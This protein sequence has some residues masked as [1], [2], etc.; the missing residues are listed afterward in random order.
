VHGHRIPK[1]SV[2]HRQFFFTE[3][4]PSGAYSVHYVYGPVEKVECRIEGK[5]SGMPNVGLGSPILLDDG[6]YRSYGIARSTDQRMMSTGIWESDDALSWRPRNLGQVEDTNLILFENLPGDQSSLA[7]TSVLRLADGRWR[8]YLWKHREGHLRLI[9]AESDDG[10][11]WRVLDLEK[12]VLYHPHDGG[13]WKLAEGLAVHEA[14]KVEMP[15]EEVMRRKR[16]WTNDSLGIYYNEQIGR[17]ECYGVWLH[18]A[19]PDRRVDVDNAPGVHRLIYRRFSEDGIEWSDPELII[20]PDE[21]DPWDLQFYFLGVQWYEDFMIGSLGYYRVEDGQQS[22]DTDLCFSRDGYRWDRPLRGGWIPRSEE[23]S[24]MMDT[25]GIYAGDRWIDR[26][27]RW[28]ILYHGTPEPHNSRECVVGMMGAVF[29]KNR[30]IGVAAGRVPGGFMTEPFFLSQPE[31]RLDASIRG[32][33]RAEL[34]DV[35]GRK[36]PGFHLMDSIPI[37]GDSEA[38]ALRWKDAA[39]ADH[40]F[41]MLRLRFEYTDGVIYGVD[42]AGGT[43]TTSRRLRRELPGI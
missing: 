28:L 5:I 9:V 4:L 8:M 38:H 15:Q 20:R 25:K 19:I 35:F 11:R 32:W 21:R 10:L 23:G 3:K 42:S 14:V 2:S 31:V 37:R 40:R 6:T 36:L 7:P 12:P 26:G 43:Q 41:E 33:L 13:L 30:F 22:M 17:F 27:D 24:G 1:G 18:P 34:C 39:I 29:T 16:L